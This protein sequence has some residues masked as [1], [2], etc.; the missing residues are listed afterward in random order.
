MFIYVIPYQDKYIVYC[1]LK[2][3]AFLAN[4]ALVNLIVQAQEDLQKCAPIEHNN[5]ALQFL[6]SVT[7]PKVMESGRGQK[8]CRLLITYLL[9]SAL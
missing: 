6:E 3:L 7:L 2:K 9:Q 5:D 8:D 4:A 1:P